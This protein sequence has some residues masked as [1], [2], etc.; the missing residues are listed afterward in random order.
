MSQLAFKAYTCGKSQFGNVWIIWDNKKQ[1]IFENDGYF[2]KEFGSSF[3]LLYE[4]IQA[5][6]LQG[7][8]RGKISDWK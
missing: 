5:D 6:E 3:W 7:L 1:Y 8:C 2:A 4:G